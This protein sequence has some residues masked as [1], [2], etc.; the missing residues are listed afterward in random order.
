M[1][2]GETERRVPRSLAII[3]SENPERQVLHEANRHERWIAIRSIPDAVLRPEI[4]TGR[5]EGLH[6]ATRWNRL[7]HGTSHGQ[8]YTQDSGE[9]VGKARADTKMKRTETIP[10]SIVRAGTFFTEGK[11]GK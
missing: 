1:V 3:H 4:G 5:E 2:Q 8:P 7:I 9:Q 6:S 10:P 11:A